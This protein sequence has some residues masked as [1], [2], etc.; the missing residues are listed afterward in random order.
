MMWDLYSKK[1]PY[2]P[3]RC[4]GWMNFCRFIFG[5][6]HGV[7][8]STKYGRSIT[9]WNIIISPH[10]PCEI[11]RSTVEAVPDY[12]LGHHKKH[13]KKLGLWRWNTWNHLFHSFKHMHSLLCHQLVL[14]QHWFRVFIVGIV[15]GAIMI[16]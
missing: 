8:E 12:M 3:L 10:D 7:V 5:I 2:V 16:R 4:Q 9:T 14:T 13:Q 11:I 15:R 1:S 6:Q